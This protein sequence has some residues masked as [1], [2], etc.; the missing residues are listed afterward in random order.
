M[1][2]RISKL[3]TFFVKMRF[4]IYADISNVLYL[5][6]NKYDFLKVPQF[7]LLRKPKIIKIGQIFPA[8][9]GSRFEPP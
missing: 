2:R 9:K 4:E 5:Q 8:E 1:C 6:D 7:F 3:F